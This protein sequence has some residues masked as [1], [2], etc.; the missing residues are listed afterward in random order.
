MKFKVGDKV[1]VREDLTLFKS[2]DGGWMFV[3]KMAQFRGEVVTISGVRASGYHIEE[4]GGTCG[5]GEDMFEPDIVKGDTKK[6]KTF[7]DLLKAEINKYIK[8]HD[9]DYISIGAIQQMV[10]RVTKKLEKEKDK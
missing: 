4:D 8:T 5:W 6:K 9:S 10:D 3:E 7:K 2:Y 1:R